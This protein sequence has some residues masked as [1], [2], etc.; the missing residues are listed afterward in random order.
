MPAY[1]LLMHPANPHS[2]PVAADRLASHLTGLGLIGAPIRHPTLTLY[3]AGERLPELVTFLG[4]A[5]HIDLLPPDSPDALEAALAAGGLCHVRLAETGALQFRTDRNAPLP[6][7]PECR[8]PAHNWQQ[9]LLD[10]QSD[11]EKHDWQCQAC[12]HSGQ[13][14]QLNFRKSAGFGRIFLEIWGIYPS[15]AVPGDELLASLRTLAGCDWKTLY[16]RE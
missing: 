4:C 5:P 3:S 16:L 10:W 7:C 14:M 2:A 6:R 12:H 13:L 11:S 9:L 1:K 15:E 8:K